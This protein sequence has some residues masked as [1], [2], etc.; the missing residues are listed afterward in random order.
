MAEVP[1]P[2]LSAFS[3][4][5][6]DAV[7]RAAASVVRVDAR[8]RFAASGIA[9]APGI[10]VTAHHVIE[11]DDEIRVTTPAG[12]EV[13]ATL[14]GRDPGSDIAVLR[15]DAALTPATLADGAARPGQIAFAVGRPEIA[16]H[17]ASFGVISGIAGAWRTFLGGQVSGVVR[18]DVTF[19]PGFSGGPLID[20]SG[21]VVGMNTSGLGRGQ[22]ITI[23]AADVGRIVEAI[24]SGAGVRRGYLG[25]G[26]QLAGL[27]ASLSAKAGGQETALLI[28]SV[29]EG[30]P[31]DSA[32]VL[33]GDVLI[34]FNDQTVGSTEDLL[35][36]LGSDTV[37]QSVT[38][39]LLRGGEPVSV[40]VTVGERGA[41]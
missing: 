41:Q 33:L 37:G 2:T 6:A 15:V 10:I 9:W 34:G 20:A 36:A 17:S 39:Q 26:T 5:L 40:A 4:A 18:S 8:P 21:A 22:G 31:A 3:D 38:L 12:V 14:A 25:I 29:E 13:A 19:L 1:V 16:S 24:L 27:P 35:G 32:G 7:E 28:V 30:S 23:P 11:S